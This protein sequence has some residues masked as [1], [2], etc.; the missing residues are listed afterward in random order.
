TSLF[1]VVLVSG[2]AAIVLGAGSVGVDCG[3]GGMRAN[4]FCLKGLKHVSDVIVVP[5]SIV[6][7]KQ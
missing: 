4:G 7:R 5:S 2:M 3:V 1:A 6:A